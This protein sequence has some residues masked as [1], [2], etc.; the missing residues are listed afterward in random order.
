MVRQKSHFSLKP[1]KDWVPNCSR[2]MTVPSPLPFFT[3]GQV[4]SLIAFGSPC[5][6]SRERTRVAPVG[7]RTRGLY[8][9]DRVPLGQGQH[10]RPSIHPTRWGGTHVA[11]ITGVA[12]RRDLVFPKPAALCAGGQPERGT[13]QHDVAVD[14]AGV[15][16]RALTLADGGYQR[17]TRSSAASSKPGRNPLIH[18]RVSSSVVTEPGMNVVPS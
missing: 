16:A 6:E 8:R 15:V 4:T 13:R 1:V 11:N 14:E 7:D 17:S 3:G 5:D 9:A 18:S 12:S 2:L 10:V